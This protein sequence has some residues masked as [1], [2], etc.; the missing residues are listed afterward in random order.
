MTKTI[1]SRKSTERAIRRLTKEIETI[2][3]FIHPLDDEDISINLFN[4][5]ALR[6]DAVRMPVL[7]MALAVESVLDG[8][9]AQKLVGHHPRKR[10]GKIGTRA[11]EL[12]ELLEGGRF[13]FESKLR[14]ARV[15]SLISKAQYSSLDRLRALRNKCAHRWTLDVIRR[16][17]RKPQTTKRLLELGG[18]NLFDLAVLRDFMH[19]YTGIYLR[20]FSK[21]VPD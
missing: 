12:Q 14:L 17:G 1:H 13:G 7:Q 9:I 19:V 10:K 3:S 16:K 18:R 11:K 4:A 5:K 20:L 21:Y 8:L 15:L 6:E 2:Q